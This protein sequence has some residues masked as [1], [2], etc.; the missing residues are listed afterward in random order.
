MI[1][2]AVAM[3]LAGS[4][5]QSTAKAVSAALDVLQRDDANGVIFF[6]LRKYPASIQ[7]ELAAIEAEDLVCRGNSG[8]DPDTMT[9]C[10]RRETMMRE[11]G[12]KGWCWGPDAAIEAD[13]HWMRAG[14]ACHY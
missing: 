1:G 6:D 4:A 12:R 7:P 13:K 11:V 3:M 10:K 8:D 9:A 5:P 14:S 2:A